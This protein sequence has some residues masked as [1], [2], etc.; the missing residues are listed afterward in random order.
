MTRKR[1]WTPATEYRVTKLPT[2]GPK[3]GQSTES[4]MLGKE[5]QDKRIKREG[6]KKGFIFSDD[7][8]SN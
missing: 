5:Q 6:Y 4:Y 2:R 3:P 1:D 7:L 8:D